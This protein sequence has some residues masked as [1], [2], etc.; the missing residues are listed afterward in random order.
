M[1][2]DTHCHLD[3]FLKNPSAFS[4]VLSDFTKLNLTP[5]FISMTTDSG[6]WVDHL[7]FSKAYPQ[8]HCSLGIHPWYA[9]NVKF[10]DLN[11]L[12]SLLDT[13]PVT[14]LGEIGLDFSHEFKPHQDAQLEVFY[15]QLELAQCFSKPV[16]IHVVK[17]HS[18]MFRA[19]SEYNSYGVIHGLGASLQVAQRYVDLGFKIGVNGVSVRSNARRYHA[20]VKHFGLD[21]L[22]LETDFPYVKLPGLVESQLVNVLTVADQLASLLNVSLDTVLQITSQNAHDVF[23]F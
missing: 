17:A 14:A 15:P 12:R 6:Q 2:I 8:V 1:I 5:Q 22:V 11:D 4:S 7:T 13:Q 23:K 10:N 16:S 3:L 21:H 20:L 18:E 19:L 9:H